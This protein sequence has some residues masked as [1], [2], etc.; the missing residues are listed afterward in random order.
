VEIIDFLNLTVRRVVSLVALGLLVAVPT[1]AFLLRSPSDYRGT[2]TVRLG[3]LLPDGGA[4]YLIQRLSQDFETALDLP[5]IADAVSRETGV[6]K[7]AFRAGLVTT[8][9]SNG[10]VVTVS[11]TSPDAT[12]SLAVARIASTE[13]L[14]VLTI[15]GVDE[16]AARVQVANQAFDDALQPFRTYVAADNDPDPVASSNAAL[17]VLLRL[18]REAAASGT[19]ASVQADELSAQID[20]LVA[21]APQ[22][23]HAV[24]TIEAARDAARQAT[25]DQIVT[26]SRNAAAG[27]GGLV[28]PTGSTTVNR[29]T[30][31]LTTGLGVG[32]AAVMAVIAILAA[33]EL[34]RG[35]AIDQVAIIV[36]PPNQVGETG[37]TAQWRSYRRVGLSTI[38]ERLTRIPPSM[39]RRAWWLLVPIGFIVSL[40]EVALSSSGKTVLALVFAAPIGL[41]LTVLAVTRFEAFLIALIVVRASLDVFNLASPDGGTKGIDP[42]IVVGGVFIVCG[43]LWL[44]AQRR[45]G[46]WIKVSAPT[47]ALWSFAGACML[48]IPTSVALSGSIVSTTKVVAGVLVFSV[49]EQYLGLRPERARA[50]LIAL[51]ASFA[52]PAL[53]ALKQWVGGEGNTY[54]VEVSRVT[55]TF[56]HPS[57]LADYLL[58]LLPI[59]VLLIGWCRGRNRV[60][61]MAITAAAAGLLIITYTRA[62]WIAALVSIAY[63]ALRWRREVLYGLLAVVALLLLAVPSVAA[64]FADLN[65]PPPAEGVPSNSLS[66]RIGYWERVLPKAKVNPVTGIGFDTVQ[67]T[68]PE[69]LEPHNVFVQAYVETG[70]IGLGA[71]LAIIW[72][73]ARMLRARVRNASPGW[74][75]L[76][77]LGA[78]SVAIA[79]FTQFPGENLLSQTIIYTYLAVA[80]TYG[81]RFDVHEIV[82]A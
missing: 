12:R 62:A 67:R 78:T 57:S 23:R 74:P 73:F 3:A 59:S 72:T 69:N 76:L 27:S 39:L 60:V 25:F 26:V 58:L 44:L 75:R 80:M 32:A 24:E 71:L 16:A 53:V 77:A 15:Q 43:S 70:V 63:L 31:V 52:F 61:M 50:L 21:M 47:W 55:G 28:T 54:Y 37:P 40:G 18:N 5:Q 10:D 35:R 36:Q 33:L 9:A 48:S 56:V 11:F 8:R 14:K 22:Y 19:A 68:E 46:Y 82:A 66:W 30:S 1:T 65:A 51:F 6:V 41:A 29:T 45:S 42:G 2:V 4:S 34:R 79:T 17:R 20:A 7:D 64:R 13:A 81:I 49:L 38:I